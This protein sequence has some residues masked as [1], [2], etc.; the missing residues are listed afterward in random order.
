VAA[1]LVLGLTLLVGGTAML[2][3]LR[4]SQIRN[5]DDVADI[6]SDDIA[7][8]ARRGALPPTLSLED[9]AVGQVVDDDGRVRAASA[10]VSDSAPIAVLHPAG[11]EPV[12]RTVDD[13]PGVEGEYRLLALRASSPTGPVTIFVGTNLEPV[14]DTLLLVRTSLLVAAPLLLALV[15]TMTW[16]TV[17]RALHPVEAIR[18]QVADL[19]SKDLHRRVPVPPTDDE[20]GRLAATMNA[21]LDRLQ[22]AADKQHRF[23][24]DAS[25]ELQSPLAAA[26]ADLEV[27]LAHPGAT[28]WPGTARDL[29]EENRHMERLVADLLF[30]ARAD[31][32]TTPAPGT[33]VDLHE[34]VYDEAA[35]FTASDGIRIDT[36]GVTSAFVLGRRDDLTRVVRNLLDNAQHHATSTVTVGL[37]NGGGAVTLVVEDDGPGVP[38][39]HRDRIFERFAR[40]DDARTRNGTGTGLGLAIV[41]EIVEQHHGSVTVQDGANGPH[42]A[43]FVV[44]LPPD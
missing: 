21:M 18:T 9:D 14:R 2:T 11:T 25:H 40:L 39:E 22:T 7:A 31:D 43:R 16:I 34:I 33:P 4:R 26:R 24:A 3:L 30:I 44:T 19:S 10:N 29:L 35:R 36:A 28:D 38:P 41:R 37:G 20:I 23:V 17:G 1:T 12:T 13:L 6:R 15:A 32:A 42:G 27:A 5:L 8:L